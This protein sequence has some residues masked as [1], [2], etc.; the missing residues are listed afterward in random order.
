MKIVK[1]FISS[2][3]G[4]MDGE[5][6]VLFG[7]VLPRLRRRASDELG[8]IVQEVDLRWTLTEKHVRRGDVDGLCLEGTE[9]CTPYFLCMLGR[10]RDPVPLP[11]IIE[12]TEFERLLGM[13][14]GLPAKHR[15]LLSDCYRL[16]SP[17]APAYLLNISRPRT[18]RYRVHE[19]LHKAG[20]LADCPSLTEQ[21]IESALSGAWLPRAIPASAGCT[22][23]ANRPGVSLDAEE[24]ALLDSLYPRSSVGHRRWLRPG[25]SP[26]RIRDLRRVVEKLGYARKCHTFLLFRGVAPTATNAAASDSR[27]QRLAGS[28]GD[29]VEPAFSAN[30]PCTRPARRSSSGQE[31]APE[32]DQ[33]GEMVFEALWSHMQQN[34]ELDQPRHS[35]GVADSS[36]RNAEERAVRKTLWNEHAAHQRVADQYA[37]TFHGRS[38]VLEELRMAVRRGLTAHRRKSVGHRTIVLSGDPGSGKSALLAG[39]CHTLK[40]RSV[41]FGGREVSVINRFIGATPRSVSLRDLLTDLCRTIAC[42]Y[43][44]DADVPT[45]IP[46]LTKTFKRLLGSTGAPRG[47][48]LVLV[49]DGLE[50][51]EQDDNTPLIGWLPKEVPSGP[52]IVVSATHTHGREGPNI[53]SAFR[54][55]TPPP[56]EVVLRGLSEKERREVICGYLGGFN[57][58]LSERNLGLLA[59][60][61]QCRDISYLHAVLEE[62]RTL[63]GHREVATFIAEQLRGGLNTLFQRKL[64]RI[65]QRFH[66]RH[67]E[68]ATRLLRDFVRYIAAHPR[69]LPETDLRL[70]LGDWQ[71]L[72]HSPAAQVR[73][74]D[75]H[76]TTLTRA[77]GANLVQRGTRWDFAHEAFR[78]AAEHTYLNKRAARRGTHTVMAEYLRQR[79]LTY[80]PTMRDLPYH[81]TSA[82]MVAELESLLLSYDWTATKLRAR[83]LEAL[84]EDYD[85]VDRP[86]P[87]PCALLR[88]TLSMC[89]GTLRDNP[90]QLPVQI[91]G[92]LSRYTDRKLR[93]LVDTARQRASADTMMPRTASLAA[94]DTALSA[95]YDVSHPISSFGMPRN[96]DIMVAGSPYGRF[97]IWHRGAGG[98]R[99]DVNLWEKVIRHLDPG[100]HG[101][102]AKSGRPHV[103]TV[104]S[105]AVTE[106]HT[107][108]VLALDWGSSI[109]LWHLKH[110]GL[111]GL[112]D[113]HLS[114]VNTVGLGTGSRYAISGGMDGTVRLFDMKSREHTEVR[115]FAGHRDEVTC[116]AFPKAGTHVISGSDDATI[117]VWDLRAKKQSLCIHTPG[118]VRDI[119]LTPDNSTVIAACAPG[120]IVAYSLTRNVSPVRA[121]FHRGMTRT[122]HHKDVC[123]VLMTPDGSRLVSASRHDMRLWDF[124]RARQ[125]TALAEEITSGISGLAVTADNR[126]VFSA[127]GDGKIRRWNISRHDSGRTRTYRARSPVTAVDISAGGTVG[128][129]GRADGSIE[130]WDID[131][132]RISYTF[133]NE[134]ALTAL[135]I[136]PEG[137]YAVSGDADWRVAVWDL[138]HGTRRSLLVGH[139]GPIR[140]IAI[141]ADSRT[142]ATCS[143]DRTIR[144]WNMDDGR[145]Y[146]TVCTM[147]QPIISVAPDTQGERLLA[148]VGDT[149]MKLIRMN[150]SNYVEQALRTAT[151][152][153]CPRIGQPRLERIGTMSTVGSSL[154]LSSSGNYAVTG[155]QEGTVAVWDLT[156]DKLLR[157]AQRSTTP[158]SC[159][160]CPRDSSDRFLVGQDNTLR[161]CGFPEGECVAAFHADGDILCC[162][163]DGGG[164][165]ALAGDSDGNLHML[166]MQQSREVAGKKEAVAQ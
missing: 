88:R 72:P 97:S 104:A 73:L 95:V 12:R 125:L 52:C 112:L 75:Y 133:R 165:L 53:L 51:L 84:L 29:E 58:A 126:Y 37:W 116:L 25:A 108:A 94:P 122:L 164:K 2:T 154:A 24:Q 69:G 140:D 138:H 56:Q 100:L 14:S 132:R 118:R 123:R 7:H 96:G 119:T 33:F 64:R 106:N 136:T 61:R 137:R 135:R 59:A 117:R 21:E 9:R 89:A 6:R 158:V 109:V 38:R 113:G 90:T 129:A 68:P 57:R 74:S 20:V 66:T 134:A 28:L 63:S 92:R 152:V 139:E 1:L 50:H 18:E 124:S 130:V 114:R 151:I 81:L 55:R 49:L 155:T 71:A 43:G 157:T 107:Y 3:L 128:V 4:D 45:D 110:N 67:G 19:I 153:S 15:K 82:G 10:E 141:T 5:R 144:A 22:D 161:L 79:G 148:L 98:T 39:L 36:G 26:A 150:L 40:E 99:S 30:Y 48:P 111:A 70:L 163:A 86:V 23:S 11:P 78:R 103:L 83:G 162:A 60:K 85:L 35:P 149:S 105:V 101:V 102:S 8:A 146:G 91:A 17:D 16:E 65:E 159:A 34:A 131:N 76:W 143:E 54:S 127:S 42:L 80:P 32:L 156:Q 31:T 47:Y 93:K 121:F 166:D 44:L 41:L 62:L 145:C 87:A 27:R 46:G 77:L 147:Q 13:T 160:T 142:A 120:R 115:T